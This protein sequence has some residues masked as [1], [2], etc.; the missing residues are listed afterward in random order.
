MLALSLTRDGGLLDFPDPDEPLERG[1]Q[2]LYA[3]TLAA[4]REQDEIR[5]N[6]KVCGYVLTGVDAP[7]SWVWRRLHDALR[8]RASTL[9]NP[10]KDAA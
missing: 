3:G 10:R 7:A 8:A 4:R 6:L 9:F 2:I 1:D 5:R